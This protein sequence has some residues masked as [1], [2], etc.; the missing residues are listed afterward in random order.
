MSFSSVG[1]NDFIEQLPF[2]LD[3][4][5]T[6][7][8]AALEERCSVV[9]CAPTG[10]GKTLIGEYVIH[11]A[12]SRQ[13]R[14]FYTTPLKALS[15]QKLRD[16]QQQFGLDQVG[17]LTGDVSINRDAPI[18]VMTTEI[19]RNMLYGTP[20]GE[21][22]TS[23]TGV[24]AVVLDECHYMND[25]QRG[26]VWEESI[27]YCPP[28]IQL[29]ALSA[30]IANGQQMADWL[31][32]VHGPTR[33]IYSDWRPIPLHFYF[34]NKKGLAPLLNGNRT[35]L[36]PRLQGKSAPQGRSRG[37]REFLDINFVIKQLQERQMLPAIYFIFSRRGCDQAINQVTGINLLTPE[38]RSRLAMAIDDFLAKHREIAAPDQIAPLYQGIA[39]HHAGVLPLWKTLI[40]TLF[41]AGLIKLIFATE[42]LAAG[43]NMPARTTVISTLSKR[44]DSGHRLLTASEFLQMAGRAGRRG[45]DEIGHVITLQTP[46]EGAKEAA[47][48]ATAS[49]DPLISQFT[50]SYGM[51]LN[52][53]QRHTLTEARD[54]IERSFGQYI[55]TL[56]L[57]PQRQAIAEVEAE[58]HQV[59]ECLG[60]IDRTALKQYQKLRERLRQE[61]RLLKTLQQQSYETLNAS[62]APLIL[63]APL[64]TVITLKPQTNDALP[65][66]ACLVGQLPGRGQFPL[67]IC[68]AQDQRLYVVEVNQVIA[69]DGDRPPLNPIPDLPSLLAKPGF[70]TAAPPEFHDL[71][72]A[73]PTLPW[74]PPPEVLEQQTLVEQLTQELSQL[75]AQADWENPNY[76][77][78][79][80]RRQQRLEADLG[81]RQA[82]LLQQSEYHWENFLALIAALQDFGGLEDLSPTPLGEMA[83]A[84]RGE[85][86]LWLALAL[87][88]GELDGLAPHHLAAAAAALVTETP[89]SDSWTHYPTAPEV[90]ESLGSLRHTRRQL[91]Q[92]QRRHKI[93][94]PIWFEWELIGLVEHWAL[95]V[96]WPELCQNTNLDAGD[97]VRLLRRTLD[98]L[99][100][101]PHAPHT[102]LQLRQTANQARY[103]LDRFPVNDLLFSETP[104]IEM[105]PQDTLSYDPAPQKSPKN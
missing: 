5:Q 90:E 69:V 37:R 101:I 48:L 75:D 1:V 38:E 42:T 16:F 43:I 102:S 50:P 19:F 60:N 54:L 70:S 104:D 58:L 56:H 12:L 103:L 24:E 99:S 100:Q 31:Q 27:I 87:T 81:D 93:I 88:S 4:F 92:V 64:G 46:F 21:V 78:R 63:Q 18:L 36:N 84:L 25:R 76:F 94:F 40:E 33:L 39:S 13:Q 28:E 41:Q 73:F 49:P 67:L 32:A 23:L 105:E 86:E 96:S 72:K 52:L 71:L 20:I 7:A 89:R 53:L 65:L 22:G 29:V 10:S 9:V 66:A 45:M 68:L 3:D 79:L 26:T 17:L 80:E 62:L 59:K 6:Q 8:I 34:C 11:R 47:Y 98:F 61:Q 55:A 97:I 44:T 77:L 82:K 85:N 74:T 14:V 95:G 30:T 51:V 91:F 35:R 57:A 83:A 2:Q 15:N